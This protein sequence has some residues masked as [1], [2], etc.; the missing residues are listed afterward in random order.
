MRRNSWAF[1]V[2][3][4]LATTSAHG[5]D[6]EWRWARFRTSEQIATVSAAA[7]FGATYLLPPRDPTWGGGV[8]F[9]ESFRSAWRASTRSGRRAG[10]LASDIAYFALLLDPLVMEGPIV[11]YARGSKDA[12]QQITLINLEALAFTGLVFR[13]IE[14]SVARARPYVWDCKNRV[15][16]DAEC[17][18]KGIRG[19][20]SFMSGHAGVAATGAALICSHQ[21]HL[22]L[23]GRV[24]APVTCAT[25]ISLAIMAGV[26]R[27]TADKHYM[28][29]V[30]AGW[31][32]GALS[33]ILV[34][35]LLHYRYKNEDT[36]TSGQPVMVS[37]GS[38]L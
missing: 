26:G 9:D 34:P 24:G 25:A 8:W 31:V 12:G 6:L 7:I 35:E 16:N 13:T 29:D 14:M 3:A 38:T 5:D 18:E 23:Y 1:G 30:I 4:L 37:F 21:L 15:A 33:G 28:T 10:A 36:I 11:P 19:T 20:N 17:H 22:N 27:I 2:A 32:I